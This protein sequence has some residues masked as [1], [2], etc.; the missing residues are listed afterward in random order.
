MFR[1]WGR[2]ERE[3]KIVRQTTY[4]SAAV[5]EWGGFFGY[6]SEICEALDIATPVLQLRKVRQGNLSATRLHRTRG[7]RQAGA[8]KHTPLNRTRH[9][10]QAMPAGRT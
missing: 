1:I 8:G 2:I 3:H 4:E 5:F 9:E 6:L 10:T 7:L